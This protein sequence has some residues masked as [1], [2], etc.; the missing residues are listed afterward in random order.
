[1]YVECNTQNT[2]HCQKTVASSAVGR[3]CTR[4]LPMTEA[5]SGSIVVVVA[6]T[7]TFDSVDADGR[8]SDGVPC[9]HARS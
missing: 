6:P 1:M 5:K 4:S 8:H 9:Q 3:T 7:W 2:M